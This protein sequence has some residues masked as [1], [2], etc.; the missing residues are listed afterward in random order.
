M[1]MAAQKLGELRDALLPF[2]RNRRQSSSLTRPTRRPSGVSR[3]SALSWRSSKPILGPRREHAIRLID[4]LGHQVVDQ[5]ADVGLAAIEDQRRLALDLEGRV[6]AGHQPLGGRF[7]VAGRAVDLAGEIQ[8]RDLLRFQRRVQAASAGRNR[9]RRH[10]PSACTSA[11]SRPGISRSISL[12]HVVGQAGADA[13]AVVFEG[14]AALRVPGRSDGDP[15]RRS[16]PPCLR[17]TGNSAARGRKSGRSTSA[18]RCRLA[19]IRSW[20]ASLV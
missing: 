16:A 9:T 19:R 3:R 17:W 11:F 18:T 5:H 10:S 15:C 13:V 1:T 7:F 8:A 4:A 6:D 12:L 20:T 2:A 14:V